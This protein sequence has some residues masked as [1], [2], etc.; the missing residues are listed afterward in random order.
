[1]TI[2]A[3]I[4]DLEGVLLF[5]KEGSLE[6]TL[7]KRL[8]VPVDKIGNIFHSEFNDR[9][10][11]GEFR[12][13]DY[14]L[15]ILDTLELPHTKLNKLENFLKEDFFI[16]PDMLERVC[17]LRKKY[18]TALLSNYSDVLRSLLETYWKVDGAFDEIIIS[19]EIKMIKPQPEIFDY[20]LKK[21]NVLKEEAVLIDDRITN[22]RGA[23]DYGLH[24]IHF[25]EPAQG[26]A[27][28]DRLI[29]ANS[30]DFKQPENIVVE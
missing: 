2:K 18:K 30:S 5:A 25:K 10:D 26:L 14:W 7:A 12:Q 20:T 24:V 27:E 6:K 4:F 1:M 23:L 3:L 13:S 11:K 19:W 16:D 28:L 8:N 29:I 21:L 22:V 15:Y 17:Q 9:V